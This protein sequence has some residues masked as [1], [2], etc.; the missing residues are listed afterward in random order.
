MEKVG[1]WGRGWSD[2]LSGGGDALWPRPAVVFS[3][4]LLRPCR[5]TRASITRSRR[6]SLRCCESKLF[7]SVCVCVAVGGRGGRCCVRLS[8]CLSL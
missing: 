8:D 5:P 7:G 4:H 2:Q 1:G 6:F 3:I